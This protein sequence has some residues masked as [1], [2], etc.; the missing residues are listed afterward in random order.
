MFVG[1]IIL[2]ACEAVDRRC[3]RAAGVGGRSFTV[4]PLPRVAGVAEP[5]PGCETLVPSYR[6]QTKR[7]RLGSVVGREVCSEQ[8][9]IVVLARNRHYEL[10]Q[11]LLS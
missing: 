7:T 3:Q 6:E 10:L 11:S 8:M 5:P 9:G 1:R 2:R 4:L